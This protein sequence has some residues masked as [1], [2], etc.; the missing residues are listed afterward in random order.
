[1]TGVPEI[2]ITDLTPI[3]Y[4]TVVKTS[5]KETTALTVLKDTYHVGFAALDVQ[6][7]YKPDAATGELYQEALRLTLG[8]DM[9]D[10]N[11]LRRL[12]KLNPKISLITWMESELA[13]RHATVIQVDDAIG[14]WAGMYSNIRVVSMKTSS[15]VS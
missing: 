4:E 12:E 14:I 8:I 15:P 11:G 3:L 10:R 6:A 2:A 1:L 7:N 13:F 9:L 5:K